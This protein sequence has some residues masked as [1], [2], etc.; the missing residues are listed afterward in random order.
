MGSEYMRP[1][2]DGGRAFK[3]PESGARPE[4]VRPMMQTSQQPAMGG[5]PH[6]MADNANMGA[7]DG[8]PN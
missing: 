6:H 3:S 1:G 4:R 7:E 5:A 2:S 8:D